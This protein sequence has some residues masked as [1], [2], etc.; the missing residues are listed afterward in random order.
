MMTR[1]AEMTGLLLLS[2]SINRRLS[3]LPVYYSEIPYREGCVN[4]H[5]T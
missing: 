1:N 4:F 2:R 3:P 5:L